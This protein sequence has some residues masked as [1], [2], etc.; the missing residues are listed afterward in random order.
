MEPKTI[1]I[2]EGSIVNLAHIVM[3]DF[4]IIHTTDDYKERKFV[5]VYTVAGTF[6]CFEPYISALRMAMNDM[7]GPW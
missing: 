5:Y 7:L 6:K 3:V 2:A 1:Y 4:S